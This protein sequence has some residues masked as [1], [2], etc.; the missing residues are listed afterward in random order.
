MK[1]NHML[2][3]IAMLLFLQPSS[4]SAQAARV[5]TFKMTVNGTSSL[6]DWEMVVQK[7]ECKT[8]YTIENSALTD[9]KDAL[10]KIP[11]ESLKSE[12]GRMM[13]N[14]TYEAFKSEKYPTITFLLSSEK[15]NPAPG[16]VTLK[17]VLSMAGASKPVELLATYRILSGGELQITASKKIKMT[18][19]KMEPPTAMMGTIQVGDEVTISFDLVFTG[20][21][22]VL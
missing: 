9:I 2:I 21:N 4:L 7:V 6:H 10:V 13:D 17:G 19:F 5:K 8:S 22:T 12:K 3:A 18:D 15:I 11:V 20:T 14:K 1:A 16:T